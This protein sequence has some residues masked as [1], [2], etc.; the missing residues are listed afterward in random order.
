MNYAVKV[1]Q[2]HPTGVRRRSGQT[3]TAVP[4]EVASVTDAMRADPWL[5]IVETGEAGGA[6]ETGGTNE[7]DAHHQPDKSEEAGDSRASR[8]SRASRR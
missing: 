4:V 8:S 6:S 1:K 5:Q 3:F 7:T 2:G